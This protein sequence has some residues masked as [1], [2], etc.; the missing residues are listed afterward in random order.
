MSYLMKRIIFAFA[1]ILLTGIA[2]NAQ[3]LTQAQF[4]D[5]VRRGA[6]DIPLSI[7]VQRDNCEK[8]FPAFHE[9][10]CLEL[11]GRKY[12]HAQTPQKPDPKPI[13]L[14]T[15]ASAGVVQTEKD[16]AIEN[17]RHDAEVK[18][19]TQL[20]AAFLTGAQVP[21]DY[22]CGWDEKQIVTCSQPKV[23]EAAKTTPPKQ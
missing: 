16:L 22:R 6:V 19:L 23:A 15:E 21:K 18:R 10:R 5:A 11:L 9:A 4:D 2:I 7:E 1:L 20:Q 17:A 12:A 8:N 14:S 3:Q 13:T